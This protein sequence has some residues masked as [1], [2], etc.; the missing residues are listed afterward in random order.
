MKHAT[1]VPLMRRL[2]MTRSRRRHVPDA[3]DFGTEFGMEMYLSQRSLAEQVR[4]VNA[5]S[6]P[7][8]W[9]RRWVRRVRWG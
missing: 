1:P 6:V 4:A 2:G 3:A 7:G 8:H 5:S 9:L